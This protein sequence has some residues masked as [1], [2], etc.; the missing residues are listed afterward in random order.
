ML[1]AQI[2][3]IIMLLNAFGVPP[4]VVAQVQIDITPTVTVTPVDNVTATTT[5]AVTVQP[6]ASPSTDQTTAVQSVTQAFQNQSA[7]V[8]PQGIQPR[9]YYYDPLTGSFSVSTSSPS[10]K[11]SAT[12]IS[13]TCPPSDNG[14][15]YPG[16]FNAGTTTVDMKCM[17]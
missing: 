10:L 15:G 17:L 1:P 13:I 5:Q 14:N 9:T 12:V 8:T 2:A 11:N 16:L 7:S 3:A 6:S 4:S